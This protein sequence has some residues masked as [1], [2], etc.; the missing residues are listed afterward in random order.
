M[1][2]Y[3]FNAVANSNAIAHTKLHLMNINVT[4]PD[5]YEYRYQLGVVTMT[6]HS[7]NIS[8]CNDYP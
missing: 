5:D 4:A 6:T 7:T 3:V 1:V 8:V 2:N